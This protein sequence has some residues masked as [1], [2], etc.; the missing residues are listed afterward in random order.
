MACDAAQL[1]E[2]S[3]CFSCKYDAL[4]GLYQAVKIR[5][6]CAIRDGETLECDP[7]V[8]AQEARCI[9]ACVPRGAMDAIEITLLC[10]I[11]EQA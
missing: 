6:L 4:P 9:F 2:A 5:L 11:M 7:D 3:K 10:A 1:L 8:L